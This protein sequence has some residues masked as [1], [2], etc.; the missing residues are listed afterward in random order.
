[1]IAINP[2]PEAPVSA[3]TNSGID[4]FTVEW[5][6]SVSD[7]V[8]KYH[9]YSSGAGANFTPTL[10]NRIGTVSAP[11]TSFSYTTATYAVHYLR[12]YSVDAFGQEST[13]FAAAQATPQSPFIRDVTPPDAPTGVSVSSGYDHSKHSPYLDVSWSAN[14]EDDLA[15][16]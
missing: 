8:V 16:Y 9:V 7:D 6:A 10:A 4:G 2:A 11:S 12:V 13:E 15:E 5:E 1:N 3:T 14:T